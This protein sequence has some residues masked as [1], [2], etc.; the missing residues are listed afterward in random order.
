MWMEVELVYLPLGL[1]DASTAETLGLLE[2]LT[3]R[4]D[5]GPY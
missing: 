5:S 2:Q 1:P 3:E 4:Q